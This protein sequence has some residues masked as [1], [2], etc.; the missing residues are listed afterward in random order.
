MKKAADQAAFFSSGR[1]ISLPGPQKKARG[2]G[3]LRADGKIPSRGQFEGTGSVQDSLTSAAEL[4]VRIIGEF[5]VIGISSH[6]LPVFLVVRISR[7]QSAGPDK[8]GTAQAFF[9]TPYFSRL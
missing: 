1:Y 5:P 7:F 8:S 4:L 3:R 9:H 6:A 2:P